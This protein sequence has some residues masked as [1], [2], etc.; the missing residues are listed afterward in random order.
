MAAA[1]YPAMS[2]SSEQLQARLEVRVNRSYL[3]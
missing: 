2:A 3:R 1:I